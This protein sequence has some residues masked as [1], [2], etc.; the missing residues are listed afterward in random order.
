M[1]VDEVEATFRGGEEGTGGEGSGAPAGEVCS[2][3]VGAGDVT[4]GAGPAAVSGGG[5]G[6]GDVAALAG[7]ESAS[8]SSRNVAA[9]SV[10]ES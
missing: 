1:I 7:A 6:N 2:G 3:E 5:V 10:P 8:D 9:P 4:E